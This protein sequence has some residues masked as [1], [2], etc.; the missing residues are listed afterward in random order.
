VTTKIAKRVYAQERHPKA[1]GK[2]VDLICINGLSVAKA[3]DFISQTWGSE[4]AHWC[5]EVCG[6]RRPRKEE[7]D[8]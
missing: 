5:A 1:L 4:A 8:E 7:A 6:D 2:Y 3:C